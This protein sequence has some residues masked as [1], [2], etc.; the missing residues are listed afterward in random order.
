MK[1][2]NTMILSMMLAASEAIAATSQQVSD[3]ISE[4]TAS[5]S[6]V[7]SSAQELVSVVGQFKLAE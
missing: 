5:C 6:K 3:G 4:M 7:N 2:L 1:A